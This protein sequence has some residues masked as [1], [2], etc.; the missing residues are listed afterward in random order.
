MTIRFNRRDALKT[1]AAALLGAMSQP[2]TGIPALADYAA[3]PTVRRNA[4]T[5]AESDPVLRGYR[6]AIVAMRA[7]PTSNPC[8]WMY[9]AA[10]HG[11]TLTPVQTAWNTC[12]T[13]PKFFWSWHRMYLYWFERIVRKYSRMHDWA[14]PYW[15]WANPAQR[16][17]PPAF[18]VVGS[19]L[20]DPSRNAAMNNGTGSISTSLGTAVTNANLLL[21]FY[22]AQSGIN[23]PHGSVHGAVS[24]NMCCVSS[25]AQDPIFWAHHSNVDRQW[26]LW[27]A[28]GGGRSNP[29]GD[30]AWR[31]T[32]FTFFDECCREVRMTS[33]EVLRAAR[34]LS[35]VYEGEPAQVEQYC[36]RIW[37]P[38]IFD[39]RV[40][41]RIAKPFR[42]SKVPVSLPLYPEAADKAMGARLL[43]IAKAPGQT[44]VLQVKGVEAST[45]PGAVWEV[46]VGPA[47]LKPDP[48]G[49]YFVGVL[50]LFGAGVKT[51]RDHYHPAEFVYPIDKAIS[52][53][54]DPTK[55]QV[56][57]V[58]VSGIEV[59]G[60]S[61][62]AEVR[63]DVTVGEISIAV[64]VAMPQ[65]PKEEQDKLRRE[66]QLQ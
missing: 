33:C 28:Q 37:D 3:G 50:G 25:A 16:Q 63:A 15:D 30:A 22:N 24:G 32:S 11:T 7:L 4:F 52:A 21:D 51:R 36:P 29:L 20:H 2:F 8:S 10:I 41:V 34:Q 55:L 40:I 49:P 61:L 66:E 56:T 58:P 19:A 13:D 35:Y 39:I 62:P 57:F 43:E 48:A 65:P 14:L 17:L 46:Y 6:R 45:E 5:M 9:Q 53:A 42:L 44:A 38:E 54:G 12:H 26:N 1:G 31:N 47:G 59:Q 27:L 64:D 60:R 18:R 23:G